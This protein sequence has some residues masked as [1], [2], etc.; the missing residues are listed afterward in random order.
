MAFFDQPELEA[1]L[2]ELVAAATGIDVFLGHEVTALEQDPD[3]DHVR[4]SSGRARARD[5]AAASFVIG[6]DGA[7]SFVRREAV[8]I[9][10][11]SLG[12]DQ[13]WLVVDI[14]AGPRATCPW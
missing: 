4:V 12:Y 1:L 7:S 9:E 2:R 6:C 3:T 8:G 10:W 13:D 14:T 5:R 11:L